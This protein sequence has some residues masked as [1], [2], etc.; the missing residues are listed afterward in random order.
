MGMIHMIKHPSA[1]ISLSRNTEPLSVTLY[2]VRGPAI[3][4]VPKQPFLFAH[5]DIMT[6]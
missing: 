1:S 3:C 6:H 2:N 4:L 5:A